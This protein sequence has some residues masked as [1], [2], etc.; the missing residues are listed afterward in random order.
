M[1]N[2][3]ISDLHLDPARPEITS[4]FLSF[5]QQDAAG[6]ESLY[7]LGDFFEAWVGDDDPEPEKRRAIAGL[8]Q[9]ADTGVQLFFMHG[10][11]DFLVG[12]GF[13]AASG[14]KL[15]PDPTVIRLYGKPV[16]LMH[17]DTL[18]TDDHEYQAFRK[19][20]RDPQWQ[21]Q[22]LA[23][24]LE[25]RL[26]MAD[27]A[28]AAS[29]ASSQGK[30]ESIMDVNQAAVEQAMGEHEVNLLLHGH[31]HRPNVHEFKL[32]GTPATRI[33]L[34]DWYTQGSALVWDETGF[35]LRSLPRGQ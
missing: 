6:V 8:R 18:C 27:E 24:P 13:A 25:Q 29:I 4:Q 19:M 17:G 34:G 22:F 32:G 21:A 3:F 33:V 11:R 35:K 2:L 9:L 20:T 1:T 10:N 30:P 26:Q 5:L 7:I 12:E 23:L 28:R 16:L 14:C 15:L 31:T